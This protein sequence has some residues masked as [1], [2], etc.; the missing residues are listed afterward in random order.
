MLALLRFIGIAIIILSITGTVFGIVW[1]DRV[2]YSNFASYDYADAA[3]AGY[4]GI[5]ITACFFSVIIGIIII[6]IAEV[7]K[8]LRNIEDRL[9]RSQLELE[10]LRPTLLS[11]R[12]EIQKDRD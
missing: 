1:V 3:F 11:I 2:I 12:T 5:I 9:Q 4:V 8:W 7:I 10:R 6:G